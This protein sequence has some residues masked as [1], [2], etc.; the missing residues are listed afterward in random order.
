VRRLEAAFIKAVSEK[1]ENVRPRAD[2]VD[3]P[4]KQLDKA[5]STATVEYNEYM[6][7]AENAARLVQERIGALEPTRNTAP[8]LPRVIPIPA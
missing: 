7:A 3:T 5:I 4:E 6:E 8:S 1:W 2:E